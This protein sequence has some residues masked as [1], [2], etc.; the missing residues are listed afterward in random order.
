M[1]HVT[2][3]MLTPD[4]RIAVSGAWD[5]TARIWD[6]HT[7]VAKHILKLG[8]ISAVALT[9]NGNTVLFG[10][11]SGHV[12]VWDVQRAHMKYDLSGH[13]GRVNAVAIS[14]YGDI[15]VSC[16]RTIIVW[17]L[18]NGHSRHVLNGHTGTVTALAISADGQLALSGSEDNT[19]RVWDLKTGCLQY[20]FSKDGV[21]MLWDVTKRILLHALDGHKTPITAVSISKAGNTFFSAS[22]DGIVKKWTLQ[23]GACSATFILDCGHVIWIA[24]DARKGLCIPGDFT[25]R[26]VDFDAVTTAP[27]TH[28]LNRM[29][30]N[31]FSCAD[32]THNSTMQNH[33][34]YSSDLPV[35]LIGLLAPYL[36]K[37]AP[38]ICML[39]NKVPFP[40]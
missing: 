6:L 22:E 16:S 19:V 8:G 18:S 23:N 10:D 17:D 4:C 14:D 21:L 38:F 11:S 26:L 27:I 35:F 3:A 33:K 5:D 9:R 2:S 40:R 13:D 31:V 12:K 28:P 29:L 36:L 39:S 7:G 30:T 32:E 37:G 20:I 15:G 24:P 34:T 25:L 1:D